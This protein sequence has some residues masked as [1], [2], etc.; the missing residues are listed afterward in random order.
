MI[1]KI[2]LVM[3]KLLKERNVSWKENREST[4]I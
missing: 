2:V 1:L 4:T 3:T